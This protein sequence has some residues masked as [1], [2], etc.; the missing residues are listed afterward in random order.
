MICLYYGAEVAAVFPDDVSWQEVV[1]KITALRGETPYIRI[2][3]K[4]GKTWFDYGSHTKFYHT[5][6]EVYRG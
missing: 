6:R 4:D 2:W 5:D 1:G 3:N